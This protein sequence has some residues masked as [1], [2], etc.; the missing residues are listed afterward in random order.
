MSSLAERC[1]PEFYINL[2]QKG[3]EAGYPESLLAQIVNDAMSEAR[4]LLAGKC[5]KCG[6]PSARYVDYDRQRGPTDIPG[7]W[8]MYRCSTQ[9]PPGSIRPDGVCDFMSDYVEGHA[10]N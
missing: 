3:R 2:I 6:A 7:V 9:P 10:A 5:P 4:S 1:K 8:V